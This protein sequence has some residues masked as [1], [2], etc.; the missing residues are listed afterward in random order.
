MNTLLLSSVLFGVFIVAARGPF[1]L[2]P[3]RALQFYKSSPTVV[4]ASAGLLGAL[5]LA[6]VLAAQNVDGTFPSV[7]SY[8]GVFA[9]LVAILL[10]IMPSLP[11]R[12]LGRNGTSVLR[13]RGI[14]GVVF[15]VV[16][17]YFS[18]AYFY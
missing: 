5:G 2:A 18:F 17:I 15:G 12:F 3:D 13:A 1:A 14:L 11:G 10:M 9:A 7:A 4:R 6:M 16:W 8:V